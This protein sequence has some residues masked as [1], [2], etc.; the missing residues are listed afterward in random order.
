M[1]LAPPPSPRGLQRALSPGTA[2]R[3]ACRCRLLLQLYDAATSVPTAST[4][5]VFVETTTLHDDPMTQ[6]E[7]DALTAWVNQRRLNLAP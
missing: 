4:C 6:A 7:K 3:V 5:K 1:V 2:A